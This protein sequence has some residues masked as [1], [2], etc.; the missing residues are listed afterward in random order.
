MFRLVSGGEFLWVLT[1]YEEASEAR[2]VVSLQHTYLVNKA[3]CLRMMITRMIDAPPQTCGAAP[4]KSEAVFPYICKYNLISD[5][6]I[7]LENV[8]CCIFLQGKYRC[9]MHL[10]HA[11]TMPML[12]ISAIGSTF[13]FLSA[14]VQ[15][16]YVRAYLLRTLRLFLLTF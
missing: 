10:G 13:L 4:T 11:V 9:D 5:S 12:V 1:R 8:I 7:R 15:Y 3:G 14:S 2:E 16:T 6:Y